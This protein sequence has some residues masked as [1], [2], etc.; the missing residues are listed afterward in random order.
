MSKDPSTYA[1][2]F[3]QEI[4]CLLSE[5]ADLEKK[6]AKCDE[7]RLCAVSVKRGDARI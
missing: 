4:R 3:K 1:I 6:I 5:V 7:E 2:A